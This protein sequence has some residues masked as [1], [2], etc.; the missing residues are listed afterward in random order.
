M[1]VDVPDLA[2]RRDN[3]RRHDLVAGGDQSDQ[4]LLED[5]NAGN[6][7]GRENAYVERRQ[8]TR[9]FSKNHFSLS[10]VF[11]PETDILSPADL[12]VTSTSSADRL[13]C[14]CMTTPSAPAG[15]IAP[16]AT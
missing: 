13:A 2:R 12:A 16:V 9:P 11:P 15:T 6:A 10:Y 8:W 5:G 14:S 3:I 4:R 7:Q 1:G